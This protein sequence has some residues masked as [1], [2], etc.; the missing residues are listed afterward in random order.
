MTGRRVAPPGAPDRGN[1]TLLSLGFAILA[2][3]VILV[4]AA[5]TG[6]HLA[7][8]RLCDAAD[9]LALQAADAMD[10]GLYYSGGAPVP[11]DDAGL[12]VSVPRARAAVAA[13]ISAVSSRHDLEGVEVMSVV[14]TDGNSVTVTIGV[15]VR[16]PFGLGS[17]LP[18]GDVFLTATS[19]ARVH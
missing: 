15:T 13:A 4:G 1:I 12:A 5:A 18:W 16:P 6:V 14:S 10:V 11:T 9:E 17:W 19:T 8:T 2:V 3:L 7:H